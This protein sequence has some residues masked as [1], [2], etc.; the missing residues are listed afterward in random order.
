MDFDQRL[1]NR[2]YA[3]VR[4]LV[5]MDS[6]GFDVVVV[7]AKIAFRLSFDGKA[8]LGFCPVRVNPEYLGGN[9]LFPDDVA[10]DKPGT[11]VGLIGTAHPVQMK[12][13]RANT[14]LAWLQ[15]GTLK[16]VIQIHGPRSYFSHVGSMV[17]TDPGPLQP[18]PL[19][20]DHAYGGRGTDG[21]ECP[22]NPIGRGY[23]SNQ[24]LLEGTLAPALEPVHDPL[25]PGEKP[26]PAHAAFAPIDAAW[27]PRRD[28]L[29][30][31]DMAYLK[32]RYPMPPLDFDPR[33]NCW[34]APGLHSPEPLRGDEPIE[35]GGVLP[36]G[37]WRFKTPL[38][39][40]RFEYVMDG[41]D[42]S[43]PTHLDG[44]LIDADKRVVELSYRAKIRLPRKWAR[45]EAV[46]A[47]ATV[48]M[49]NEMI[50]A[51]DW[52]RPAAV[53]LALAAQQRSAVR[54]ADPPRRAQPP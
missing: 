31:R 30:T 32:D 1:E 26:H 20:Y 14:A 6:E 10:P 51:E 53:D 5:T 41:K 52:P 39:P 38:Y 15:V 47:L 4:T 21:T 35:V 40:M 8:R 28:R 11:D 16:K 48:K 43:P 25:R 29:G 23:A 12:G 54:A 7:I 13:A 24:K 46:R 22:E 42:Q 45:L 19:C 9:M 17:M 3:T 44:L 18:T 34:S 37:T 33:F 50:V 27:R 2:S 49:P 36:E